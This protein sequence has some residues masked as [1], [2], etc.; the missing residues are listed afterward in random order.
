MIFAQPPF[1]RP[2]NR[3]PVLLIAVCACLAAAALGLCLGATSIPPERVTSAL[4]RELALGGPASAEGEHFIVVGLRL[5]RVVLGLEIGAALALAGAMMQGLFRN[6][7]ADPGLVGVTSGAGLAVAM[8]IV[9]GEHI[10]GAGAQWLHVAALP[11][12]AFLGGLAATGFIYVL[13]TR[14]GRTSM[15]V[16]LLA[17]VALSAFA[18]AATALLSYLSDDRQ[19]RD[20]SFWFLGS[21]GGAN[22]GKAATLA[23]AL[24]P[25]LLAMPWLAR[26]LNGL[27]FGEAEA[28][29]LGLR[30]EVIKGAAI[31][32]IALAVGASVAAA[33]A[34]GFIG[35]AA[36][37]LVRL[38]AGP[39]HRLLLPLSALCGAA[40]LVGADAL[41]RTLLAPAE[42][43]V[44][45]LTASIGAPFFLWL[46]LRD[47]TRSDST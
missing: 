5:P 12:D 32:L 37:H 21:L 11:A 1:A 46:L 7:L 40:L 22:W 20:L 17:G 41:A 2:D 44:G 4:W 14:G 26:G 35:L 13:A 45:I 33:G 23:L 34:I 25:A 36:P 15:T 27:A 38:M 42:L 16:M 8:T 3:A 24:A 43:P 10:W 9:L 39:D 29:H 47:S 28:F 19:L 18:G 30:A 6:P 31:G